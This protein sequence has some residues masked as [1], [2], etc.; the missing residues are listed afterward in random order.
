MYKG[1]PEAI[2][3]AEKSFNSNGYKN[4]KLIAFEAAITWSSKL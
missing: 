4:V 3:I 1:D 2:K